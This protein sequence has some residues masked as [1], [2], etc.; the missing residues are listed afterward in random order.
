M[1]RPGREPNRR[2][3]R[4]ASHSP[5]ST[6]APTRN[7]HL[8][9]RTIADP[10]PSSI[11]G[12]AAPRT[13]VAVLIALA[14]VLA[15][16]TALLV[17]TESTASPA[18]TDDGSPRAA[19]TDIDATPMFDLEGLVWS[20]FDPDGTERERITA[21]RLVQP[22]DGGDQILLT[23][24]VDLKDDTGA[25]VWAWQAERAVHDPLTRILTSTGTTLGWRWPPPPHRTPGDAEWT[26]AVI[27]TAAATLWT[28]AAAGLEPADAKALQQLREGLIGP[29][30][31]RFVRALAG[32]DVAIHL[33]PTTNATP[34]STTPPPPQTIT[35][36]APV[37]VVDA[38]RRAR[39]TGWQLDRE[40]DR[41]YLRERVRQRQFGTTSS[42]P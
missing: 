23:A 27:E 12:T 2:C 11:R 17:V 25:P 8:A 5:Q 10:T 18:D 32:R 4:G 15:G 24:L 29:P 42:A 3:P 9:V 26:P 37:L 20:R 31:P 22:H 36:P 40:T 21:E 19:A 34:T 41:L 33:M 6:T 39:A 14:T 38:Q 28:L 30:P 7:A 13:L 1:T 16:A 35:S